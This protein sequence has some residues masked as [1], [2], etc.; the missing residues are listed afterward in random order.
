[1]AAFEVPL[2][3]LVWPFKANWRER[4]ET[5]YEFK[6]TIA[7]SDDGKEQRRALRSEPR[8]AMDV[9]T[10][11]LEIREFRYLQQFVFSNITKPIAFPDFSNVVIAEITSE[12]TLDAGE[13]LRWAA[14]G[15]AVIL[16]D[17]DRV[18]LKHIL[19]VNGAQVQISS[20]TG[21]SGKV[22]FY[23]AVYGHFD[24]PLKGRLLTSG[25]M[26]VSIGVSGLPGLQNPVYTGGA[27]VMFDGREVLL[28]KMD[29]AD[30]AVDMSGFTKILDNGYSRVSRYNPIRF[31]TRLYRQTFLLETRE[32]RDDLI[33]FFCRMKGRRG[34]FF[35]PTWTDD[36]T[37]KS[38]V[39]TTLR[40]EPTGQT[41]FSNRVDR[42]VMVERYDGTRAFAKV[43]AVALAGGDLVLTLNQAFPWAIAP[44]EVRRL[45]WLPLCRFGSDLLSLS[46]VSSVTATA[47]MTIQTL[48]Y[49]PVG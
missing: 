31:N 37:L 9:M 27:P 6:S 35:A 28:R 12:V 34:E 11:G 19:A 45:C 42:A 13:T 39:G 43:T 1:M 40:C 20:A 30:R 16:S 24:S 46:H 33:A 4:V 29:W 38:A 15:N 7:V 25:A 21:M 41:D 44:A 26:E 17:G 22:R 10:S 49:L 32:D 3:A 23:P 5:D 2:N 47:D 14:P 36:L 8:R 18:E 48:E